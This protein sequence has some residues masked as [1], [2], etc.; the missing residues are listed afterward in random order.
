MSTFFYLPA[1][2]STK[3]L[4]FVGV[5]FTREVYIG[6]FMMGGIM[7]NNA[8]LLT[9]HINRG[10]ARAGLPLLDAIVRGTVDGYGRF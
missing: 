7:V 2:K 5:T 1:S 9:D 10:R 4:F 8:I 6:V 3:N